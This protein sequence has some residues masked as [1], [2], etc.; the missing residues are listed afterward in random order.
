MFSVL[1][2]SNIFTQFLHDGGLRTRF[3]ILLHAYTC[4]SRIQRSLLDSSET[5][6]G[7][8]I[9]VPL[10]SGSHSS[11]AVSPEEYRMTGEGSPEIPRESRGVKGLGRVIGVFYHLLWTH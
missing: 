10:I 3:C 4:R 11:V 6:L 9:L 1:C 7:H 5:S 8:C 2:N